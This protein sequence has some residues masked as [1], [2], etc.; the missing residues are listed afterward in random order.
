M[1]RDDQRVA[2]GGCVVHELEPELPLRGT[3]VP[4][5]GYS[6]VGVWTRFDAS[7]IMKHEVR[8]GIVAALALAGSV[9]ANAQQ[10]YL[11][12]PGDVYAA[13]TPYPGGAVVVV[14]SPYV[15]YAAVPAPYA[16]PGGIYA[17][18]PQPYAYPTT[19]I[20]SRPVRSQGVQ[21]PVPPSCGLIGGATRR[22]DRHSGVTVINPNAT[23]NVKPEKAYQRS[24][25]SIL[26]AVRPSSRASFGLSG[27]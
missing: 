14:P 1:R 15:G 23:A 20:S 17:Y 11:S 18:A 8:T 4:N 12:A 19:A 13:P 3:I 27:S 5:G 6:R 26:A 16:V 10:V 7:W 21:A 22:P 25:Y 9:E 2:H 24:A